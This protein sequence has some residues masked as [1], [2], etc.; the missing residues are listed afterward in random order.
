MMWQSSAGFLHQAFNSI[1]LKKDL[2]N[3]LYIQ[4][5]EIEGLDLNRLKAW[6]TYELY[7]ED[8]AES[9]LKLLHE[10]LSDRNFHDPS[11]LEQYKNQIT[12]AACKLKNRFSAS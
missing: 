5:I 2:L 9:L 11:Y 10:S 1:P 4:K 12:L 7:V 6:D 8:A 3:W